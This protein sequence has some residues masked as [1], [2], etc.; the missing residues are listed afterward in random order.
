MIFCTFS[1]KSNPPPPLSKSHSQSLS[2][3]HPIA[4]PLLLPIPTPPP[5]SS[6]H[7][8]LEHEVYEALIWLLPPVQVHQVCL[9]N[10][11]NWPQE[12][13]ALLV[14]IPGRHVLL[15]TLIIGR[16]PSDASHYARCLRECLC[17]YNTV[18]VWLRCSHSMVTVQV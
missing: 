17:G 11:R 16:P 7:I 8:L 12:L 14:P 6:S 4:Y 1:R 13:H 2:S 15:A 5:C 18:L 10:S 9:Q 3:P